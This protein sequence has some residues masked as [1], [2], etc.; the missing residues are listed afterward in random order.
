MNPTSKSNSKIGVTES[1]TF[2]V[3]SPPPPSYFLP[4]KSEAQT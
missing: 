2:M 3:A 1:L 4:R